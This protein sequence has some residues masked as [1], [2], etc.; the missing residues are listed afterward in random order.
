MK[1][2]FDAVEFQRK[3]REKLS[4]KYRKNRKAFYKELKEQTGGL[5]KEEMLVEKR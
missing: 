4:K 2:T 5:S 1:K 3:A